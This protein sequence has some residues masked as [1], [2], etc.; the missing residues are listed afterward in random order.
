MANHNLGRYIP[1][2]AICFLA[3]LTPGCGGGGG[4]SSSNN[5]TPPAPT[6]T[7]PTPGSGGGSAQ[8]AIAITTVS[9]TSPMA[10][11]PITV[12]T[13]GVNPSASVLVTFSSSAG[14]NLTSAALR[15]LEDGSVIVG[16]PIFIDPA[17][18]QESPSGTVNMTVTQGSQSSGPVAITI[19]QLPSSASYGL[20]LGDISHAFLQ[21]QALE[22]GRR[23]NELQ[24]FQYLPNNKVDT[25]AV[26][27][28]LKQQL[29]DVIKVRN[30]VDRVAK[31]PS[32]VIPIAQTADGVPI[33]FDKDSVDFMDRVFGLHLTQLAPVIA[34][35]TASSATAKAQ[36]N[37]TAHVN[38][39]TSS[40]PSMKD[41]TTIIDG[42]KFGWSLGAARV[43]AT[44]KDASLLDKGLA[45]GSAAVNLLNLLG[46]KKAADYAG[47]AVSGM[48][49]LNDLGNEIGAAAY[50]VLNSHS[51]VAGEAAQEV[52]DRHRNVVADS[53][54]TITGLLG[55]GVDYQPQS[56]GPKLVAFLENHSTA[57]ESADYLV[58]GAE[59]CEKAN[60]VE[61]LLDVSQSI[62]ADIPSSGFANALQGFTELAGLSNVTYPN[63]DPFYSEQSEIAVQPVDASQIISIADPTGAYDMYV[64]LQAPNTSY[65]SLNISA[66]DPITGATLA[67]Q[68]LNLATAGSTAPVKVPPMSGVCNDFDVSTPDGDDPD[69]D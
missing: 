35:A 50:V 46:L 23:I 63:I 49:L 8:G 34:Q 65:G 18:K 64:P 58:D 60:C 53:I 44:Q 25:L 13:T 7:P 56:L 66:S 29:Q 3:F 15:V 5:S 4:Q 14:F 38:A 32:L 57:L 42:A 9:N 6:Q 43:T 61:K 36:S 19:Q 52:E 33:N 47:A 28:N 17:T 59:V 41:L 22:I 54:H 55:I 11:T 68:P 30:D 62:M 39:S 10:M 45:I 69:C 21:Y 31:N 16:T 51:P 24:L 67:Q 40:F 1:M 27:A 48:T 2:F 37:V 20:N 26:Q 12:H